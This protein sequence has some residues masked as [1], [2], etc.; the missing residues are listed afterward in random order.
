MQY[1]KYTKYTKYNIYQ[2]GANDKFV[3]WSSSYCCVGVTRYDKLLWRH[4][5]P[6]QSSV[7]PKASVVGV[8]IMSDVLESAAFSACAHD[9][10]RG[11]ACFQI[12]QVR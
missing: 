2:R 7:Q 3:V 1:T 5:R 8:T 10:V 4:R 11:R 6:G 9:K 12:G